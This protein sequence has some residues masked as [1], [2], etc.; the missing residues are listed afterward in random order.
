[1]RERVVYSWVMKPFNQEITDSFN[2]FLVAVGK[3]VDDAVAVEREACARIAD[4]KGGQ[5]CCRETAEQIGREIRA[6]ST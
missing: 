2:E 5:E 1:M 3:A 6:R 4:E